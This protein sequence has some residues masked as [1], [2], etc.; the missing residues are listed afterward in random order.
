MPAAIKEAF[1]EDTAHDYI[2]SH[3]FGI[4]TEEGMEVAKMLFENGDDYATIGAEVTARGLT[5]DQEEDE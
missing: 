4:P 2:V 3:G 5:V 1:D